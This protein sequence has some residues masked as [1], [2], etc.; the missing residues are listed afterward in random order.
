M[1]K[2]DIIVGGAVHDP[3]HLADTVFDQVGVV[4]I[5][6]KQPSSMITGPVIIVRIDRVEQIGVVSSNCRPFADPL[7]YN[8]R[9]VLCWIVDTFEMR[10][11]FLSFFSD[12]EDIPFVLSFINTFGTFVGIRADRL[13]TANRL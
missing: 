4:S 2:T 13:M 12:T 3:F 7:T 6:C 10:P 1:F 9:Q 5:I 11:A 8:C